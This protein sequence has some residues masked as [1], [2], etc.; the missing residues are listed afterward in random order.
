VKGI[1]L[2]K[3]T[4]KKLWENRQAAPE[5][6]SAAH[7][8]SE[9]VRIDPKII[10]KSRCVC[11]FEDAKEIDAYRVIREQIQQRIKEK[12]G[13]TLMITSPGPGEGKTLTAINLA[14]IFAKSLD[15]SALL[16]DC[17]LNK[18]N[19]HQYLGIS[20]KGGIIDYLL[21]DRPL[22]DIIIRPNIE[23]LEII[24]GGRTIRDSSELLGS[25]RMKSLIAEMKSR[26]ADRYMFFDV[27]PILGRADAIAFAPMVDYILVVVQAGQ[28]SVHDVKKALELIPKDKFMGFILNRI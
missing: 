24:S 9:F 17:D 3:K 19:I 10:G 5:E 27:P 15:S 18:Q 21:Y 6:T 16:A 23:K 20:G 22:E 11:V 28:T 14:V 8:E 7:S 2:L 4:K 26:Y 25:Q 12:Q 13:N 1:S